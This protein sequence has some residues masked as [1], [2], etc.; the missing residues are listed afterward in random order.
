V[1]L[2]RIRG[3]A[4]DPHRLRRLGGVLAERGALRL[5]CYPSPVEEM[6]RLREALGAAPR[7]LVKRDDAL[8]FAFG[9]NKVRKLELI[10]AQALAEGAD[11]LV[12]VGGVQSNHARCTAAFAAR[13]GLGCVLVLNGAPPERPSGNALLSALYGAE[14]EYVASR[15][16]REPAMREVVERLR[17]RGARPFSIPLG[18]STPVGVL[19]L[20]AAVAELV[21][22][23]PPPDVIV[24]AT[25]SGGTQAGIVA[26][27]AVAGLPTRVIGVSADD[28]AAD[29][30]R[31]VRALAAAALVELGDSGAALGR[32]EVDEGFVGEG[33]GVPTE[34]SREAQR[35]AA[36][37]EALAVEQTYT[38]KALAALIAWLRAG[39]FRADET[40]LFWHTGG[41]PSLF[42]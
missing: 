40:V 21:A 33:Y 7:L 6:G 41:G 42:A 31:S 37:T 13:T 5:A 15:E 10:V 3:V 2:S 17:R 36:R 12:T 32:I 23:V 34:A 39:R 29:I 8:S 30:E 35:L 26:G 20:A 18:C 24:H 25:S 9:G 16:E 28:P 22:Q 19:G 27:C 1:R 14:V 4:G 38:A 11:T